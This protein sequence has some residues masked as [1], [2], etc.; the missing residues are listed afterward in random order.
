[1]DQQ[2][3]AGS[4]EVRLELLPGAVAVI[5]LDRPPLN[6]LDRDM[7]ARLHRAADEAAER[8]DVR[9]VVVHGGLRAFSAGADIREMAGMSHLAMSRHAPLLQAAFNA[10]AA[11]PKPVIAAVNGPALGGGCEL[12]L[13]ADH[14]ICGRGARLGLPEVLLGVMPGAGGTQRLP[15]LVGP[16]HAKDLM[17]TGRVV[18]AAE[19]RS[20]GLVDEVVADARVLERAVARA[21]ALAKGPAVALAAIKQ[22]VDQGGTSELGTGLTLETRLFSAL[23]AT[24]DRTAGMRGFLENGPGR[25]EFTGR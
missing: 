5:R 10:V 13:T 21:T 9:A 18:S 2:H 22:A 3:P 6:I 8:D 19:A 25:A 7:Q 17:M 15:R 23:F 1:M 12:A 11:I 14:R 16:A 4:G 24:D 20:I